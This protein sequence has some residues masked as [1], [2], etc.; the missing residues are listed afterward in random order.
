MGVP[1]LS[2]EVDIANA[3]VELESGLVANVTASRVS[4][5]PVRKLRIFQHQRYWSV[6]YRDQEIKGFGLEEAEGGRREIRPLELPFEKGEPLRRELEAFV[7]ACRQ[8]AREGIVS[9]DEGRR[10]LATALEIG[11]RARGGATT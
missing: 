4:A 2:E 1:V 6:D 11:Q 8:G 10:A 7:A 3:R 5:E 9:G